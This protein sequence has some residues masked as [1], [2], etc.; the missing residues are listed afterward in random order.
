MLP[1]PG[2]PGIYPPPRPQGRVRRSIIPKD[3][4]RRRII[5]LV[6]VY[7]I[8]LSLI[9]ITWPEPTAPRTY[10][11]EVWG[12]LRAN[13][14]IWGEMHE[15]QGWVGVW[16]WTTDGGGGSLRVDVTNVSRVRLVDRHDG[17][18]VW[19]NCTNGTFEINADE[20]NF[21]SQWS[22]I[23]LHYT[24]MEY[25]CTFGSDTSDYNLLSRL[26]SID[27]T[28]LVTHNESLDEDFSVNGCSVTIDGSEYEGAHSLLIPDG[29]EGI[30]SIHGSGHMR[31]YDDA[32]PP[33]ID[34]TLEVDR[35]VDHKGLRS[36]TFQ[37][38][39]FR[40]EDIGLRTI[41]PIDYN[42]DGG[43]FGSSDPWEIEVTVPKDATVEIHESLKTPLWV[44]Y[45]LMGSMAA[46]LVLIYREHARGRKR[47]QDGP[48]QG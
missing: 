29:E 20:S 11:G 35:F 1:F 43:W 25:N 19:V 42:G 33:H 18:D 38:I 6:F 30:V 37:A 32:F 8:M 39:L 46:V 36:D 9:P 48:K 15:A 24:Y 14:R 41:N 45:V 3:P 13:G 31:T 17:E 10:E 16:H 21:Y 4:R 12:D 27:G 47:P 34:G 7:I 5:A 22:D 28:A 44:D 23:D 2:P 26:S 40:G